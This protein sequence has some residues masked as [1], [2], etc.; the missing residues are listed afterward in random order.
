MK[1]GARNAAASMRRDLVFLVA[2]TFAA[3][4]ISMYFEV[5][6]AI[7]AWTRHWERYQLDE[8]PGILL[9]FATG[10]TW[11][12]WRRMRE[13]HAE[14]LR[15]EAIERELAAALSNN[16]RLM[17][18]HVQVQE[19]ERRRIARELHDELG[20]H[21]NAMKVDAVTIRD[22]EGLPH[23]TRRAA[24]SIIDVTDHLHGIVRNMIRRLRPAGLDEL[25][26]PAAIEN[27]L[28]SLHGRLPEL[29]V[30]LAIAGDFNDLA[31]A[32][33]ITLYRVIQEG[34][35]NVAR[36]ANASRVVIRLNR[37]CAIPHAMSEITLTISDD[38]RG[39]PS[40]R[41]RSGLGLI[42]MKERIEALGGRFEVR[43]GA[44]SGFLVSAWLPL[45]VQS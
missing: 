19:D 13:A 21:L 1:S 26:L 2:I 6:E 31:E 22:T 24:F 20:Q 41:E 39:G 4:L 36:H 11:F 27:Y 16:R 5:S 43:S 28:Q 35:T 42:G 14:I 23:E 25:G 3:A 9:V 38:G 44:P 45:A 29:Q 18:T 40:P 33:N 8:Y 34:L 30:D 17:R 15:R 7:Q 37:T 10:M 12:A 32:V